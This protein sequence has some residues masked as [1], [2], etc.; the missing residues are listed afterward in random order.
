VEMQGKDCSEV[1]QATISITFDDRTAIVSCYSLSMMSCPIRV[2]QKPPK[3]LEEWLG[4]GI[5]ESE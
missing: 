3:G 5:I 1:A 2:T 4:Q